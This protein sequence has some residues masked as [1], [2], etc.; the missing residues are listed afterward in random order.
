[1]SDRLV[2]CYHGVDPERRSPYSVTPEQLEGHLRS[3]IRRGYRPASLTA[4]GDAGKC[5]AVTFDDG[6]TSVRDL[7]FPVLQRAGVP[8]TVFACTAWVGRTEPM[9]LGHGRG[10]PGDQLVSLG[11]D[12]L[13]VLRDAGWEIGS[14]SRTHRRLTGLADAELRDELEGSRRDVERRLGTAC[15]AL[16][17][18]HG[19]VDRRV[20]AAARDAGYSLA[21]AARAG[22]A[23]DPLCLPR[24]VVLREDDGL[25]M[26]V[27]TSGVARRLRGSQAAWRL[28]APAY[29]ALG[30][31]RGHREPA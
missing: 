4:A 8:A 10:V 2:L 15:R 30:G 28:L 25:R 27:K 14:H 6:L 1:M 9:D 13:G 20:I 5:F 21:F 22:R 17:Y 24:V 11:W 3:L 18:P 26:R 31:G 23:G 12:D 7:A 19:D 16:A 29:R